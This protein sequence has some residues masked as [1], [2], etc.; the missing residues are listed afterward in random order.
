[1]HSLPENSWILY[2]EVVDKADRALGGIL[3]NKPMG[4]LL[5][6][7]IHMLVFQQ[8]ISVARWIVNNQ[9]L[10]SRLNAVQS[11]TK[12]EFEILAAEVKESVAK[13]MKL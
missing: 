11:F 13:L 4:P 8:G 2:R 3:D 12:D 10:V 6:Q 9:D 1:M 5:N 7:F